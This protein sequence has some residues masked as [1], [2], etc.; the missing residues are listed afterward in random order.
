M[1]MKSGKLKPRSRIHK[2]DRFTNIKR[3]AFLA[4]KISKHKV[5]TVVPVIA[6]YEEAR[7]MARSYSEDFIEV[8]VN[9]SLEKVEERDVKGLYAKARSG[10]IKNFTGI[11]DP[12]EAP[13]NPDIEHNTDK[14]SLGES[15]EKIFHKLIEKGY[16]ENL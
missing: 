9:A 1:E 5:L 6:P 10:E 13:S 12:Y 11:S 4:G 2:E 3:I 15:V 8:F 7:K 14:E 16:V